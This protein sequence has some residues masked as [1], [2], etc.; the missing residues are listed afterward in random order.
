MTAGAAWVDI[1]LDSDLDLFLSMGIFGPWHPHLTASKGVTRN[2]IWLNRGDGTFEDHGLAAGLTSTEVSRFSS[3]LDI[4]NDGDLDIYENNWMVSPD[5]LWRNLLKETGSLVF[6]E[7]T[8]EFTPEGGD[9]SMPF[10]SFV[11]AAA[12]F[13]NDG[14]DDL[15]LFVRGYLTEGPYRDGH[16]LL[17]NAKGRA[18]VDASEVSDLNNPFEAGFLRDHDSLGVMGATARDLNGDGLPDVFIGNGGPAAGFV[19]QLFVTDGL[20]DHDFGEHG[21]LAVPHFVNASETI[22]YPAAE[23]LSG[24]PPYPPYPYRTHAGCVADFDGDGAVELAVTNGGMGWTGSS[25]AEEPNRLFS[26]EVTPKPR[27]LTVKLEGNGTTVH[28]NAVGARIEVTARAKGKPWTVRDTLR[29][30]NG[31][32]AQHGFVRWFGLSQATSADLT[33]HWPDGSA[34]CLTDVALDTQHEVIQGA[35]P[36]AAELPG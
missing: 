7:V 31:F 30:G 2:V 4:D 27:F 1:D 32:A 8:E 24:A 17:L 28:H 33:V 12:D 13:N 23:A 21:T 10:E 29:T 5:I 34:D 19:N 35:S 11:S 26:S 9:L 22:D 20:V 14:W 36:C 6:E 16:V 25:V 15:L 18:F 3:L